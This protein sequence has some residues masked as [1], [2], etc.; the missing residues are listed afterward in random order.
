M[1]HAF[2]FV[3]RNDRDRDGHGPRFCEHMNRINTE[4]GAH[5]TVSY[6]HFDA[7]AKVYISFELFLIR[8]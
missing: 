3:T 5:I 4:S 7:Y 2:L 8:C 6:F 1:I